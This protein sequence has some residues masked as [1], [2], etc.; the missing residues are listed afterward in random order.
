MASSQVKY[1][2][3]DD[4]NAKAWDPTLTGSA[5]LK[6]RTGGIW[7]TFVFIESESSLV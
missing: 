2:K 6:E 4:P 7:A 5:A 3:L 1:D